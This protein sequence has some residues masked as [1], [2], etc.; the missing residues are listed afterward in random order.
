MATVALIHGAGDSGWAWH[1]VADELHNRGH[2]VVAPDL[3]S[4]RDNAGLSEYAATVSDA[5]RS[6]ASRYPSPLVVVGHSLGA[7]TAPLVAEQ[8]KA[9][10]LVLIAPMIPLPGE[11]VNEW[12]SATGYTDAAR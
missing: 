11:T 6:T 8:Q 9:N 12:W 10:R 1:R 5:L 7:F 2:T 3:P 4:E